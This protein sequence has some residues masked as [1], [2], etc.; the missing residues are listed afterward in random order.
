[1]GC[2]GPWS[3]ARRPGAWP[4][5]E[6]VIRRAT[7]VVVPALVLAEIDYVLRADRVAMRK[8]V[9]ERFD[10]ATTCEF[11][12]VLPEDI[13]RALHLDGKFLHCSSVSSMAR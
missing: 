13:V 4:D 8:L 7:A 6:A 2:A 3:A 10:P 5:Y 11:E 1:V 12:P 9:A